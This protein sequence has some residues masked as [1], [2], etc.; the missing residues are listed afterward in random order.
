MKKVRYSVAASLDG[1]IAGPNGEYDWIIMDPAIDFGAFMDRFDTMLVGRGTFEVAVK[2][3]AA[4]SFAG[5]KT[6]V[7]STTLEQEHYPE[8]TIA[9]DAVAVVS[10]LRHEAGKEI[11]LMGG[12][13]LFQSLLTAGLV[14][15][16]EIAVVPILLGGGIQ[17][18]PATDARVAL[19][20]TDIERYPSGIISL[21]Y[22]VPGRAES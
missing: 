2:Q 8:V 3:A 10:A 18:L 5:L 1:Y 12:G 16:V 14:D 9:D 11:W 4:E 7:F 15:E 13:K 20:L 17:M 21:R 22:T 6:Y 19:A